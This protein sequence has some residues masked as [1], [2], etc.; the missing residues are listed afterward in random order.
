MAPPTVLFDIP[1]INNT[2]RLLPDD[3]RDLSLLKRISWASRFLNAVG[4]DTPLDLFEAQLGVIDID[5]RANKPVSSFY[6]GLWR[7]F[8][9]SRVRHF[10]QYVNGHQFARLK[11]RRRMQDVYEIDKMREPGLDHAM[12]EVIGK[13][14]SELLVL[15]DTLKKPIE[16]YTIADIKPFSFDEL[17]SITVQDAPRLWQLLCSFF[18]KT[19]KEAR[20]K[21]TKT[22]QD[23]KL[24][25]FIAVS[26]LMYVRSQK[27]NFFQTHLSFYLHSSHVGK[28]Q[29]T[30]LNHLRVR[31]SPTS[32]NTLARK[33]GVDAT[34]ELKRVVKWANVILCI[35][36]IEFMSR[37]KVDLPNKTQH[38]QSD[39]CG[40]A[41][42]PDPGAGGNI[43]QAP[44][45]K[46]EVPHESLK[47]VKLEDLLPNVRNDYYR[48]VVRVHVYETIQ[49][50]HNG[51]Y[52]L[53][54]QQGYERPVI[55]EVHVV[56]TPRTKVYNLPALPL[57]EGKKTS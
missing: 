26:L 12:G 6:I 2:I 4:F 11:I 15:Q 16:S 10:V 34:V 49:K 21:S 57:N 1:G 48:N 33:L 38:I 41:F 23:W 24:V 55:K 28:R 18:D 37:V 27:C 9:A 54:V 39:T 8:T 19:E 29:V 40:Y 50:H 44:V 51:L 47:D 3:I 36:N 53:L 17:Q 30:T 7:A 56:Q 35:D 13:L 25:I 14:Q 45:D 52:G 42:C 5:P 32:V 46:S 20:V 31:I 22:K 43:V